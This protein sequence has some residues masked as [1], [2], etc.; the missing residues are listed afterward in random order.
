M[1]A[2]VVVAASEETCIQRVMARSGLS[3]E[4]VRARLK[5]QWPLEEK[6]Q[7]ADFVVWNEGTPE[8]LKKQ[9]VVLFGELKKQLEGV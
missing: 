7:Q 6:I 1:D 3:E 9:A 4:E 5:N 8:E 2:T